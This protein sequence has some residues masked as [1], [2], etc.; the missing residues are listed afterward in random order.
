MKK[1]LILILFV[2]FQTFL[3]GQITNTVEVKLTCENF[4]GVKENRYILEF[5]ANGELLKRT[6]YNVEMNPNQG[7]TDVIETHT[8]S[9]EGLLKMILVQ[10]KG[11]DNNLKPRFQSNYF[12]NE[13]KQLTEM[14]NFNYLFDSIQQKITF[15]Y[16]VNGNRNRIN[17]SESDY[18]LNK[19]DSNN[20]YLESHLF[21]NNAFEKNIKMATDSIFIYRD[22]PD[23]KN[24]WC[25]SV[26]L[27]VYNIGS[28]KNKTKFSYYKN[29][30]IKSKKNSTTYSDNSFELIYNYR[31]KCDG[32]KQFAKS[33]IEKIN[34]EILQIEVWQ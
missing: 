21:K 10:E 18:V 4:G 19:F 24:N 3:F 8:Y 12:Y 23:L 6:G 20:N 5:G 25:F 27:P 9:D 15:E 2:F 17:M 7:S 26:Y 30:I 29:G 28:A 11:R 14:I 13:K 33:I 16:D 1:K 22:L 34:K 32:N 31:I